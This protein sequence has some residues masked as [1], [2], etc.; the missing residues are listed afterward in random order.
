MKFTPSQELAYKA[1]GNN[2]LISAGAGSGKTQVLSERVLY[3]VKEKNY[4]IDDFLI[5]TFT[6]LAASEMKHRIR[7]KLAK[8]AP[9]E[10]DKVDSANICTFDSYSYSIVKKYHYVLGLSSDIKILDDKIITIKIKGKID[11][12]LDELYFKKDPILVEFVNRYC[13]KTDDVLK[14]I[15][16]DTYINARDAISTDDFIKNLL[17][18]TDIALA[19]NVLNEFNLELQKFVEQLQILI[20]DS[21]YDKFIDAANLALE[22]YLNANSLDEQV[23][24]IRNM[25][26]PKMFE[27]NIDKE[28]IDQIKYIREQIKR[29]IKNYYEED[30]FLNDY[31][32]GQKFTYFIVDI[33]K[34]LLCFDK[35]YKNKH[36]A[37]LFSDI[38]KMAIE[39]FKNHEDIRN[40]IKNSLKTIMID[41]YQD[42]SLLQEIF[43]SYISNN[44][45]Y[46]VGD[47]KQSIYRFRKATPELFIEKFLNYQK[48]D[49]KNGELINL[50]DNFRSRGEVLDDINYIFSNLM[51]LECG[52]ADYKKDHV[53]GKGN[54]AY[55]VAGNNNQNHSL[56]VLE[57]KDEEVDTPLEEYEAKLIAEDIIRKMNSSYM[58]FNG[59]FDN[60]ALRKAKLDDFCIL[61]DRGT[62]FFAYQKVFREYQIPLFVENNENIIKNEVVIGINSFLEM[63]KSIKENAYDSPTFRH[64]FMSFGRSFICQKSDNEL[65]QDIQNNFVDSSLLS[66]VKEWYQ[67]NAHLSTYELI[68]SMIKHFEVYEKLIYLGNV[69]MYEAYL[70]SFLDSLKSL[71]EMDFTFDEYIAYFKKVKDMELKIEVPSLSTNFEAVKIMNIFKSKGLEFPVVYCSGLSPRFNDSE[72]KKLI[73]LSDNFGI[74]YPSYALEHTILF[75]KNKKEELKESLS[76]KIRIFYVALTRAKEKIIMVMPNNGKEK[77]LEDSN[78]M[79][80]L[81]YRY[82]NSFNIEQAVLE[83]EKIIYE[84]QEVVPNCLKVQDIRID[85]ELEK[86]TI[87]ASKELSFTSNSSALRFGE[88]MHE[89]FEL[90]DFR[91]PDYSCLNN[92]EKLYLERFLSLPIIKNL[93]NPIFYKEYEFND[94]VNNTNGIIDCL[95]IDEGKAIIIDYKLRNIEDENYQKQLKVYYDYVENYFKIKPDCYLYSIL[96]GRCDRINIV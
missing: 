7:E 71:H 50:K 5:L 89:I 76:E 28:I 48:D 17:S 20:S 96:T 3:L 14:Q 80:D 55:A 65:Y 10:C 9:L 8:V 82:K 66:E 69:E 32:V 18:K 73:S 77:L 23:E 41:E 46:M 30:K 44:N 83:N 75:D 63:I 2:Y 47:V 29:H 27:K 94:E 19:N 39:I 64:A 57:Y 42:T 72:Y 95:I 35:E 22:S 40:E 90:T 58:V 25:S 11:E 12:I 31:K 79:F 4:H 38:A 86:E 13:F 15:I 70:D 88:S 49:Y 54:K 93:K 37:F 51:T 43:I 26:F 87:R 62:K 56:T 81:F 16:F 53:I 85:F 21:G 59:S 74:I 60:P 84:K 6:N 92:K 91:N 67:N 61:L 1:I 33:V 45:V 52:G 24:A 36:Q 78:C 34:E 68:L